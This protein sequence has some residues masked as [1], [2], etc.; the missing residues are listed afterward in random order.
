MLQFFDPDAGK[1][2]EP[3]YD[4]SLKPISNF[5]EFGNLDKEIARAGMLAT[6]QNASAMDEMD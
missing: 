3:E 6:S 2:K 4:P 5:Q 1:P